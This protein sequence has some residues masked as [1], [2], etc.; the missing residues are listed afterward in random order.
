MIRE[1]NIQFWIYQKH[2]RISFLHYCPTLCAALICGNYLQVLTYYCVKVTGDLL[3]YFFNIC[4]IVF[5]D[6]IRHE[7]F[8]SFYRIKNIVPIRFIFKAPK[9]QQNRARR[10]NEI[11]SHIKKCVCIQRTYLVSLMVFH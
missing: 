9:C 7:V 8:E 4:F 2:I 11:N 1:V 3:M 10:K 6:R 5:L